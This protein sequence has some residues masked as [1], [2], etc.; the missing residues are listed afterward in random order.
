ML[1]W[2]LLVFSPLLVACG[3]L[4]VIL[5]YLECAVEVSPDVPCRKK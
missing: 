5:A 2:V 3:A 4:K 1:L